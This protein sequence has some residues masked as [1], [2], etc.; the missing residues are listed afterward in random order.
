MAY[1]LEV[2]QKKSLL[3]VFATAPTGL[4]HL[5]VTDALYHGL[6]KD[7]SAL[8]LGSQDRW[9]NY[10]HRIGSINP[11]IREVSTW[12]Q[13]GLP[14]YIFSKIYRYI[15]RSRTNNIYHQLITIIN[16]RV[17]RPETILVVAT[18]FGLGHQ[19]AAVKDKIFRETGLKIILIVQVTD[20]SPQQMWY[21]DGADLIFVPSEKTKDDLIRFGKN[22]LLP[23]VK[24]VVNPYPTSPFFNV[25]LDDIL[26]SE[27]INQVDPEN[28][29]HIHLAIPISGAAVGTDFFLKIIQVLHGIQ[30]RYF[31][32]VVSK[33]APYTW[34]FLHEISPYT[35]VFK[36]ISNSD[37]QTIDLYDDLYKNNVIS[38]EVTK[39][40]E[41]AFK[42]LLKP[43]QRGGPI[44]LFSNPIGRQEYDNLDFLRRFNFIP[45]TI[46]QKEIWKLATESINISH[47]KVK[48][49]L[50]QCRIWR[51]FVLPQGS[52]DASSF[53][54]WC[55][56][57][58]IFFNMIKNYHAPNHDINQ[59]APTGVHDFW[60]KVTDLINNT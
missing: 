6:P 13:S 20:D 44:M 30:S 45:N 48:E 36:Y 54:H 59:T 58:K 51:G 49:L 24:F 12:G 7:T 22:D 56:T 14:E 26:F 37:R 57:N 42:A 29:S 10:T 27:K 17:E 15:L 21:V 52:T 25:Y 60:I 47:E 5:R 8:I 4:G 55:L 40:S 32:H 34:N 33:D 23:Y 41:Q 46:K 9:L 16:Q 3:I 28:K 53:I 31:F 38:L 1:K 39:P 43:N 35:F 2:L 50:D 18:H 19:I 11:I